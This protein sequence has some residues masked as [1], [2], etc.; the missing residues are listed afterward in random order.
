LRLAHYESN[1]RTRVGLIERGL[2]YDVEG[3]A[4][5]LN[6]PIRTEPLTVDLLLSDGTFESLPGLKEKDGDIVESRVE[7]IG[8]LRNP[9]K[10]E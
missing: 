3:A 9:V 8:N 5:K 7:G 2:V 6:L 4:R 10:A 1:G